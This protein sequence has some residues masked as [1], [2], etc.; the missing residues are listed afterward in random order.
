MVA[1]LISDKTD[2][3]TKIVTRD[4]EGH[5]IMITSSIQ[6]KDIPFPNMYAPKYTK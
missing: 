3:K 4:K 6:Q 2:I 5:Y 1:M